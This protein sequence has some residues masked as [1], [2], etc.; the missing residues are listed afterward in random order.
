M[1][2]LKHALTIKIQKHLK[3]R[4]VAFNSLF[5][6]ET[7]LFKQSFSWYP[8]ISN[9]MAEFSGRERGHRYSLSAQA[10]LKDT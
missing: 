9:L 5:K 3:A 7:P 4:M 8:K 2:L 6:Q 1:I 10:Y